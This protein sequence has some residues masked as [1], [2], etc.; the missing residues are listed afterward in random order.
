MT[1]FRQHLSSYVF[2]CLLDSDS[3]KN[4]QIRIQLSKNHRIQLDPQPCDMNTYIF[5]RYLINRVA[6]T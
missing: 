2:K 6:A 3:V 5:Q 4:F 1:F